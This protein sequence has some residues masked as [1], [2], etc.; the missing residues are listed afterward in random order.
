MFV[1]KF[2]VTISSIMYNK[3]VTTVP[4]VQLYMHMSMWYKNFKNQ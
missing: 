2:T 3:N 1:K 4:I